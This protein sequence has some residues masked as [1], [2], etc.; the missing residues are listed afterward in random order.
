MNQD[1][2]VG[3]RMTWDEAVSLFP[4]LW[5][6]FQDCI[7]RGVDFQSGKLVAVIQDDDIGRYICAHIDE[8]P[9]YARTTED[10]FGGY[11][12]GIIVEKETS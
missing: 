1:Q 3:K 6:S 4:D 11:I 7:Y 9:Y 8:N 5:V 2:Y 12:H 10:N